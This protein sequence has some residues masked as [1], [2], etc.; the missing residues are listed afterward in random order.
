VWEDLDNDGVQD[1][2]EP[3][4]AGV[5]LTLGGDGSG[6]ATTNSAGFYLFDG[7]A[8]G[9]Y[10]V[11]APLSVG[12][13]VIGVTIT[14][15]TITGS[16]AVYSVD[17]PAGEN[18]LDADYPYVGVLASA[19]IGD[20]VCH[21]LNGNGVQDS[22]EPGISGVTITLSGTSAGTQ[23]S[24]VDG[25][26]LFSGLDAGTY[27]VSVGSVTLPGDGQTSATTPTSYN[28]TLAEDES[29]LDADF[30]FVNTI[31]VTGFTNGGVAVAGVIVLG[32]GLATLTVANRRRR[33][34]MW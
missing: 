31:P 8:A 24:N 2:N 7:L 25:L 4:I 6:T 21:D 10:T 18:F 5:K 1:S 14:P 16:G 13:L 27:T 30:C 32:L 19:Q 9:S 15:Y 22:G 28:V 20:T 26:Y 29:F 11:T 3:G 33:R 23:V 12:S 34:P 17:L